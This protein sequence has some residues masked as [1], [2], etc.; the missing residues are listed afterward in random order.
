[1]LF[2]CTALACLNRLFIFFFSNTDELPDDLNDIINAISAVTLDPSSMNVNLETVEQRKQEVMQ[3]I[4]N[5]HRSRS[6]V[7]DVSSFKF[8]SSK[9]D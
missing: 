9:S 1:M 4:R 5:I 7:E 6:N 2:Y 3:F 8:Y